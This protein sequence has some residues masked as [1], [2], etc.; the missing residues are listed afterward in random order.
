MDTSIIPWFEP[1]IDE[2]DVE[3]VRRQ[4]AKGYVNE[5]QANREFED[6][7]TTYFN[8]PYAIT[9]PSCTTALALSL[10]ALGVKQGDSVLVPDITFIGTASAVRLAG[11]EPILVD[12]DPRTF[13]MDPGHAAKRLRTN[14]R[15]IIPVHLNGR[16]ADLPALKSL[17]SAKGLFIVEDA[18][19]ALA[20]R[21]RNG[22]LGAQ[23]DAGCFSFAPT[24][25]IT[26]GQGGF[27]L[28]HNGKTRDTLIRL[29]DHGRLSRASDLHPV[30][31]YNFKVTDMQG[32][33]AISQWKK[34][35]QRIARSIQIDALYR[36]QLNDIPDITFTA[37]NMDG[38]YLMWPDLMT[39]RR[40]ELVIHLKER[41]I[42]PRPFWPAIHSQ[43]AYADTSQF[44]GADE[45]SRKACWLPCSP[46]ISDEQVLRVTQTIRDFFIR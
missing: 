22:Y 12:V 6:I 34:L 15:G 8:V 40:N 11:A 16:S 29:K 36:S 39:S 33:L 41:G 20:S 5:G 37:R 14:T 28:T 25:I 27:I 23:S 10:M 24:K 26:C 21:N 2:D 35:N 31:G 9:T 44:P 45:V 3:A 1:W 46:N 43:P 42:T 19:E 13:T 32:A 18:A 4:V 30:T 17:A 7:L 38:G